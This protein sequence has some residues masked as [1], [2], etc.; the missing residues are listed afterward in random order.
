[1]AF[2]DDEAIVEE[3]W[4][5]GHLHIGQ[6]ASHRGEPFVGLGDV[7]RDGEMDVWEIE[8]K[9]LNGVEEHVGIVRDFPA[10]ESVTEFQLIVFYGRHRHAVIGEAYVDLLGC[11]DGALTFQEHGRDDRRCRV[12]NVR[13]WELRAEEEIEEIGDGERRRG[14]CHLDVIA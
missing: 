4:K 8:I 14:I 1:M 2:R 11:R 6:E 7:A 12:E 5:R 10:I 13:I 3:R 9:L